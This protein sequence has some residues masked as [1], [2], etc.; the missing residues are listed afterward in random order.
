LLTTVMRS[1]LAFLGAR[2]IAL[3]PLNN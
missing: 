2:R 1:S 3:D